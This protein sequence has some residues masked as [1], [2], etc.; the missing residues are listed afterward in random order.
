MA[1]LTHG[2]EV[3]WCV[4][5]P[6]EADGS[7]DIDRAKYAKRD[8]ATKRAAMDYTKVALA[9]DQFGSVRVHEF[10]IVRDEYTREFER[11]YVG[12]PIIVEGN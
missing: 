1:T 2:F 3:E 7:V 9:L 8:F 6:R 5:L 12:N 10:E 4:E 11:E